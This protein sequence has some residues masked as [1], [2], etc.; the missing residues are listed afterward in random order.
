MI[1]EPGSF[2]RGDR[3]ATYRQLQEFSERCFA[4]LRDGLPSQFALGRAEGGF[5]FINVG[6]EAFLRVLGDVVDDLVDSGR[7]DP[8][9]QS[10]V[11]VYAAVEP[12]IDVIV[13]FL[14]CLPKDEGQELR[15][16]FGSSGQ[17]RYWRTLQRALVEKMPGFEPE[18][19][20]EYLADQDKKN[21]EEAYKII[22]E[23]EQFL[24]QDVRQRLEDK[25]GASWH[26]DGVPRKV[27]LDA[28]NLANEKNLD[29]GVDEE[30]EWWDCLHI[31]DYE[32]IF[33]QK[34]ALWVELFAERYSRPEDEG[35]SGGWQ[36]K[37]DWIST[38]NTIRNETDHQ[39]A[40]KDDE[41]EFLVSLQ[42]W[43]GL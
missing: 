38:L 35:K 36:A 10:A 17:M 7:V 4:R 31:R 40:I 28:Q 24:K 12:Y 21:N 8:R 6:V 42:A 23:V 34:N 19:L 16:K 25:F 33:K 29:R 18:G 32:K 41:Y 22:R 26:K 11:D 30:V 37:S 20:A 1:K 39:Y 5:V 27:Y 14:D 15:G 3:D 43:L 9:N 2:Y 13:E